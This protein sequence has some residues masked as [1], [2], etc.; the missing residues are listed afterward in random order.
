MF[1]QNTSLSLQAF[2]SLFL[3]GFDI[4]NF[5]KLT[6]CVSRVLKVTLKTLRIESWNDDDGGMRDCGI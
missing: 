4:H 6:K 2:H 5:A 1:I 3:C